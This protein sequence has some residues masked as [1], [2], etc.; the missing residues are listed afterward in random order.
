MHC[1]EKF[2]VFFDFWRP[3][4][5]IFWSADSRKEHF[6]VQIRINNIKNQKKW[7]NIWILK[8]IK[9]KKKLNK[10]KKKKKNLFFLILLILKHFPSE[11][12]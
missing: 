7:L 8:E 3:C 10:K 11:K 4:A 1:G 9:K 5:H 12:N 6:I 2:R